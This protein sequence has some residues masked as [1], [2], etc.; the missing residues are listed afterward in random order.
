MTANINSIK[1]DTSVM[2]RI[3]AN[4]RSK[5]SAIVEQFGEGVKNDWANDVSVVTGDYKNSI[6]ENSRLENEMLYIVED[7]VPYG[8]RQE[9]GFV[10]RDSL[11]REYHQAAR[12]SLI[13]A[14]E[15][16]RDEFY[17][18]FEKLFE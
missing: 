16:I 15:K 6:L 11:G 13:P 1:I 4:L 2:D 8:A 7:G 5:A 3:T 12:P 10:G 17:K 9:L 18:T 14:L